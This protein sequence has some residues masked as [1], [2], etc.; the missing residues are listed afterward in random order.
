MGIAGPGPSGREPIPVFV[1]PAAGSAKAAL[2]AL[3]AHSGF[4]VRLTPPE[5]LAV[6]LRRAVSAGEP[7]VLVAGGDGTIASA[8]AILTG[9][10]TALAVLPGGTLNHFARNYGIPTD[11]E[12][13]LKVAT[14]GRETRVDV[15]YVN[16]RLFFNTSSVGAYVRFVET[17]RPAGTPSRLLGGQPRRGAADDRQRTIQPGDGG[18]RG[19]EAGLHRASRLHRGRR[20]NPGAPEARTAGRQAGRGAARGDPARQAAGASVRSRVLED[21]P[22]DVRG[23]A[24]ARPRQRAGGP[25]AARPFTAYREGRGGRGDRPP[26]NAV[27]VSAGTRRAEPGGA[28]GGGRGNG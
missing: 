12:D 21:G 26:A 2:A 4:D 6:A 5:R 28:A 7:R 23:E 13:A 9:S 20:A 11:L 18:G 1:N 24:G 14:G 22:G 19:R 8:A 3:D 10:D 17:P 15:G 25:A 16:E 27:G